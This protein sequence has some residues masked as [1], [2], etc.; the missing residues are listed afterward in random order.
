MLS[1]AI[2][3]SNQTPGTETSESQ[4]EPG[5]LEQSDI[6]HF[7]PPDVSAVYNLHVTLMK[8]LLK[9]VRLEFHKM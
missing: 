6:G 2:L 5:H 4:E 8:R 3:P 7:N 1:D 9:C